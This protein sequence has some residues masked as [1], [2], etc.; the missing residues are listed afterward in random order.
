MKKGKTLQELQSLP[1]KDKR[2]YTYTLIIDLDK[3]QSKTSERM[4]FGNSF[5]WRDTRITARH[6]PAGASSKTKYILESNPDRDPLLLVIDGVGSYSYMGK[7]AEDIFSVAAEALRTGPLEVDVPD[8][9]VTCTLT[10]AP[11]NPSAPHFSNGKIIVE[12]TL[13]GFDYFN[14]DDE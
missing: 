13:S 11:D 9:E 14:D 10:H 12:V 3:N 6:I 7:D 8:T 1:R 5:Y 4:R 2:S